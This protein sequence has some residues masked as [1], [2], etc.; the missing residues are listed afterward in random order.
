MHKLVKSFSNISSYGKKIKSQ[1]KKKTKK[2]N[3]KANVEYWSSTA[4]EETMATLGTFE[5]T[6]LIG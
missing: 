4:E 3:F 6:N 2:Q 5:N 1:L